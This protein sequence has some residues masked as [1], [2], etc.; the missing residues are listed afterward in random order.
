MVEKAGD[1]EWADAAED[2]GDGGE[3]GA[4]ANFVGYVAFDNAIFGGS[5]GID[6]DCTG[7]DHIGSDKAGNTSGSDND[8]VIFE[9]CEIVA[10]MEKCDIVSGIREHFEKRSANEFA[11][12]DD[13]DFLIF[14]IDVV[15]GEKPQNCGGGGGVE[16]A[17]FAKAIH[18]FC[19]S[20]EI[21]ELIGL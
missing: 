1:G 10:V 9:F 16:F 14:E 19:R 13:G 20:D 5:A 17:V 7:A 21:G 11:A 4:G 2:W 6:D 3:V 18:I 12:T 15:A 8:I